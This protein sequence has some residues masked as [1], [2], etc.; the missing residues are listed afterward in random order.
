[1]RILI[2]NDDGIYA[3]GIALLVEWAKVLGEVT[4][5]APKVEQSGKSHA[6]NF[7]APVEIRKVDVFSGVEAYEVDSTPADCIRFAT[8]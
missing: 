5:A 1:M 4:V 8:N 7:T 2:T 3:E 6:I